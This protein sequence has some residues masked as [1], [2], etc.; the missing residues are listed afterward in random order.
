MINTRSQE[1]SELLTT[2]LN[3]DIGHGHSTRPTKADSEDIIFD[4]PTHT[5]NEFLQLNARITESKKE[6]EALVSFFCNLPRYN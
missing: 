3:R 2:L 4:I 6:K 5:E 1:Q